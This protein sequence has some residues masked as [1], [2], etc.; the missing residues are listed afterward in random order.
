M[1]VIGILGGMSIESTIDYIRILSRLIN[2]KLGGQHSPKI[3]MRTVD[4]EEIERLQ[5]LGEWDKLGEIMVREAKLIENA[6]ADFLV[7]ATNTM[8]KLA[9]QVNAAI[10]IPLLHIAEPTVWKIKADG[11]RDIALLGTAFTMEQDFYKGYLTKAGLNVLIP[12]EADRAEVHRII[13]DELCHGRVLEMSAKTCQEIIKRLVD[14]GAKGVILGC[15]EVGMLV[16]SAPVP[17]YD[18]TVLH[19]E[20]AAEMA[21]G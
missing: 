11:V 15:T 13:Y 4:F 20:A 6:G 16:K 3:A 2:D 7:I 1:K 19:M 18:T 5:H 14:K 12:D 8:H 10:T 21:T 17:I 9:P